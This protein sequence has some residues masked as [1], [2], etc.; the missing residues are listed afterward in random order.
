[1]D[2]LEKL[3]WEVVFNNDEH[4]ELKDN[5]GRFIEIEDN[6]ID[7]YVWNYETDDKENSYLTKDEVL[8]LAEILKEDRSE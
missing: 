6:Y 5:T 4:L 1:M 8:A 7:V 2:K 3:G